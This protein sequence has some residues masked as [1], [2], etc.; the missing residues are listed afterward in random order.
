MRINLAKLRAGGASKVSFKK[1]LAR[2]PTS[3]FICLLFLR[4][5]GAARPPSKIRY[6]HDFSGIPGDA[7]IFRYFPGKSEM[8]GTYEYCQYD[9]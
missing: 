5:L 9:A 2:L 4:Y 1:T 3:P 6:F 7:I 8:V